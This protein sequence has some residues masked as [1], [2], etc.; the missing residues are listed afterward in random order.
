[1]WRNESNTQR[2]HQK[3]PVTILIVDDDWMN[4]ELL[5]AHLEN[6][7]FQTLTTNN[8]S[9]AL[10]IAGAQLPSLI[11]LDVRMPGLDGFEVCSRLKSAQATSHI[12]VLLITA[13]EDEEAKLKGVESGADDF[14]PKPI[15]IDHMLAQINR[16]F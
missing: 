6:A 16:F 2:G 3:M 14:V 15:D 7:G 8:G 13:L 12:P 10:E 4:R 11:L 1:M 5:Q 9:K